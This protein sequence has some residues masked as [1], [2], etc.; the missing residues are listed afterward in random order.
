MQNKSKNWNG[1]FFINADPRYAGR[2]DDPP[3]DDTIM[4]M[5]EVGKLMTVS[6]KMKDVGLA[7]FGP[8]AV[9]SCE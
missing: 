2:L 1:I 3:G 5:E 4:L 8:A 6:Q 7:T 9:G